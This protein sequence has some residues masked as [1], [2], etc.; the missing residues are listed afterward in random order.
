MF[1]M[2]CVPAKAG[3]SLATGEGLRAQPAAQRR[4]DANRR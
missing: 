3:E 1:F 4:F 2:L